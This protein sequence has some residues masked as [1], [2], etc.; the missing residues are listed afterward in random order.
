MSLGSWWKEKEDCSHV[1]DWTTSTLGVW[2]ASGWIRTID[3]TLGAGQKRSTLGLT[4]TPKWTE[5]DGCSY[6]RED[7][8]TLLT[9][10]ARLDIGS[11]GGWWMNKDGWFYVR[12][13]TEKVDFG[14]DLHF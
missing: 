12:G 10:V 6:I 3:S 9:P 11:L 13:W 1:R 7:R 8:P 2:A 4:F 14:T 5:K